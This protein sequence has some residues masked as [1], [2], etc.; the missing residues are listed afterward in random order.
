ME[1]RYEPVPIETLE[2]GILQG[3]QRRPGP[4]HPVGSTET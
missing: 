4:L 2:D 1:D 3:L